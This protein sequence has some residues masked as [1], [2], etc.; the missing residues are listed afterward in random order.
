[1]TIPPSSPR[2]QSVRDAQQLECACLHALCDR[3]L[4]EGGWPF[5]A[6]TKQTAV[7]PTALACLALP[8]NLATQCDAAIRSLLHLQNANGSWPAFAGDD[9]RGSGYTGLALH[10]LRRRGEQGLVTSRA[11]HWLLHSQ[12][13]EAHWLWKWKFRTSDRH[14]RFDPDKF[15]WPWMPGTVSWVVPT[16][17]SLLA[18]KHL[19]VDS[20]REFLEFRIRH[21]EAML[22]DRM[23]PGGGWNAGNGVVY[24][25]S[26]VPHPDATAAAL[27]ALLGEP[28]NDSTTASLNWLERRAE[29]LLAPWSLAWTVLALHAFRRS[30]QPWIDR[31]CAVVEPAK[32]VDCATLA[33]ACLAL[34]C[35]HGPN[36]FG[37]DS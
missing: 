35:A 18:L 34:R 32:I 21:G 28:L 11:A 17:Y 15:G 19:H 16:A 27:L 1:M 25:V 24:G 30:T 14:V 33:V 23:C 31:L 37:G 10:A 22:H 3:Q 5:T 8:P 13:Q 26:L 12:G 7:E 4:A 36:V 6:S 20:E 9:E 29:S 2:T